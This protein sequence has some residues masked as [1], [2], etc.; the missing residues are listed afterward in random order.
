MMHIT[1]TSVSNL[2]P[3]MIVCDIVSR[4]PF[5]LFYVFGFSPVGVNEYFLKHSSL[6]L[7]IKILLL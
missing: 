2:V 3:F 4:Q 6:I 1:R 7:A 5:N